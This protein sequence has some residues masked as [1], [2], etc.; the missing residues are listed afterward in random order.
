MFNKQLAHG[1]HCAWVLV[2]RH[3]PA[4]LN[5]STYILSYMEHILQLGVVP[6]SY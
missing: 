2:L 1:A 3:S 5:T 6:R 4:D